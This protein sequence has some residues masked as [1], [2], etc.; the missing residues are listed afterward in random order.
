MIKKH[1]ILNK[2]K[3][4]DELWKYIEEGF[5][6]ID[7]ESLENMCHQKSV[8]CVQIAQT[9]GDYPK[10]KN[11]LHTGYRTV[12]RKVGGRPPTW[13]EMRKYGHEKTRWIYEYEIP[14]EDK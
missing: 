3:T 9:K 11:D 7:E 10:D 14:E 1:V 4:L 8:Q 6:K 5:W 12:K 13:A 2:P